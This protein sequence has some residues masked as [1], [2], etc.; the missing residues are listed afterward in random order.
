M[1]SYYYSGEGCIQVRRKKFGTFTIL[2]EHRDDDVVYIISGKKSDIE[3]MKVAWASFVKSIPKGYIFLEGGGFMIKNVPSDM[4]WPKFK[5]YGWIGSLGDYA[6]G[7]ML[8]EDKRRQFLI[9]VGLVPK[10]PEP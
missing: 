10:D 2:T 4:N 5:K 7:R 8:K 3:N 1:A 9:R 6:Y